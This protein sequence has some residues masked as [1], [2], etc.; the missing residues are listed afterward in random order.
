MRKKKTHVNSFLVIANKIDH[1]DQKA[2]LFD[3]WN[4]LFFL[5]DGSLLA[6]TVVNSLFINL[7]YFAS[8]SSLF[9]ALE[10]VKKQT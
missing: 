2:G 5:Q 4:S 1:T 9:D 8:I 7:T 3:S 6:L 10:K